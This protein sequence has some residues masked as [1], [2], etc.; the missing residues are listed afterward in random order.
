[1]PL[2]ANTINGAPS[3]LSSPGSA[4]NSSVATT[5]P[6]WNSLPATVPAHRQ[7]PHDPDNITNRVSQ[8]AGADS[9]GLLNRGV[10]VEWLAS[11]DCVKQGL[12]F[13]GRERVGPCPPPAS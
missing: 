2:S 6:P 5:S 12:E 7:L 3:A 13:G 1:M 8:A 10:E 9:G 4:D 11:A